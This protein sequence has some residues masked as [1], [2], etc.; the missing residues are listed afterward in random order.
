MG[1]GANATRRRCVKNPNPSDYG[2]LG[3]ICF[4]IEFYWVRMQKTECWFHAHG[5]AAAERQSINHKLPK[6]ITVCCNVTYGTPI[7][8]PTL[9]LCAN[10][11]CT[12]HYAD[13]WCAKRNKHIF[14]ARILIEFSTHAIDLHE[15]DEWC[16]V[17]AAYVL[18]LSFR[19]ALL[20]QQWNVHYWCIF[21]VYFICLHW[22]GWTQC[23]CSFPISEIAVVRHMTFF[24]V[25]IA[26]PEDPGAEFLHWLFSLF[27]E[28]FKLICS[29]QSSE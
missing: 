16:S 5:C 22:P 12:I 18:P 7:P 29:T 1:R 24:V 19:S 25:P 21:C 15:I 9:V 8:R 23:H 10:V 11:T 26:N 4:I 20:K 27:K 17:A 6:S 3:S 14:T 13:I 28:H 2:Y